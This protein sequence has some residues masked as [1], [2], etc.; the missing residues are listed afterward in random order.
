M[1]NA[2]HAAFYVAK[3]ELPFTQFK[4]LLGL[5]NRTGGKVP[6]SY[7][8]DKACARFIC[9]IYEVERKKLL[10]KLNDAKYFTLLIDGATDCAIIENELMYVRFCRL[11]DPSMPTFLFKTCKTRVRVGSMMPF[12]RHL[13][14][15]E[16]IIGRSVLLDLEVMVLLSTW[17]LKMVWVLV[18]EGCRPPGIGP[19][20]SS[21]A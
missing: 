18:T 8:S 9:D 10:Q 7:N 13:R 11:K 21:S 19:L 3:Q 2:M 1:V 6:D 4:P 15:L 5:M 20:Y 12:K 14:K 17:G 16:L